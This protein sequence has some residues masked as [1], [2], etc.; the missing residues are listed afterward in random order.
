MQKAYKQKKISNYSDIGIDVKRQ[1]KLRKAHGLLRKHLVDN[2]RTLEFPESLIFDMKKTAL[3]NFCHIDYIYKSFIVCK[4][5]NYFIYISRL[6][7]YYLTH[8]N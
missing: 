5:V 2:V 4:I 6:Y 8:K 3:L 1:W 7:L